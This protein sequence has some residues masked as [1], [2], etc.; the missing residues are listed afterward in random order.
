MGSN[1]GFIGQ[2][3]ARVKI[4]SVLIG[5][6]GID[7]EDRGKWKQ[8]VYISCNTGTKTGTR[9]EKRK[10]TVKLQSKRIIFSVEAKM[11]FSGTQLS[12]I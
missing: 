4:M 2:L 9:R 11:Y 7:S 3:D 1:C 6:V 10:D 5:Q 12:M 8:T